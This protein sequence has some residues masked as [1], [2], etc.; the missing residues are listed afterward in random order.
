MQRSFEQIK[1]RKYGIDDIRVQQEYRTYFNIGKG[2]GLGKVNWYKALL[3]NNLLAFLGNKHTLLST[4]CHQYVMFVWML[5]YSC[6][7][8][9]DVT[10]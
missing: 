10:L 8:C 7:I 4:L 6:Y 2:Y 1:C 9:L 5:L 3:R